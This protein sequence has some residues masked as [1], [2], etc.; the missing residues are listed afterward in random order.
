MRLVA[1]VAAAI[2]V[3]ALAL[4]Q[5]PEPS[6][7]LSLPGGTSTRAT[8][9]VRYTPD[10]SIDAATV[11]ITRLDGKRRDQSRVTAEELSRTPGVLTPV[12]IFVTETWESGANPFDVGEKRNLVLTGFVKE[13]ENITVERLPDEEKSGT[14]RYKLDGTRSH[15]TFQTDGKRLIA[16]SSDHGVGIAR[17]LQT[18]FASSSSRR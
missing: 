2:A 15:W 5:T 1:L 13:G 14:H 7:T 4:A 10:G 12:K 9:A 3:A 8:L 17:E 6:F 16:L 18:G 11:T